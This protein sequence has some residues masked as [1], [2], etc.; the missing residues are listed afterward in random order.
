MI[1]HQV[2]CSIIVEYSHPGTGAAISSIHNS[3]LTDVRVKRML[4]PEQFPWQINFNAEFPLKW[5]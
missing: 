3:K 5:N 4:T 2:S 1:I